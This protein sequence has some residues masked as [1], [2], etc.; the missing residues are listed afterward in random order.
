M[1]CPRHYVVRVASLFGAAGAS[2]KGG[3]FVETM[4]K[5]ARAGEPVRVVDDIR[6]SPT[7]TKDAAYLIREIL[8]NDYPYGVY[9]ATNAGSCSW[10]EFAAEIF[11]QLGLQ[12]DLAPISRSALAQ[13]AQ[14]PRDSSLASSRLQGLAVRPWEEALRAYLAEKGYLGSAESNDP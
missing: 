5:K 10:Y 7:Y 14:R 4:V 9:H 12:V 13:K 3:N 11:A 1:L 8:L 6:M 2:G